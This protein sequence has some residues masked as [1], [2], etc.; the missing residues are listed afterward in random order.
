MANRGL[1]GDVF[2]D[3][4]PVKKHLLGAGTVATTDL[5]VSNFEKLVKETGYQFNIINDIL[6][7][8]I[9]EA[10]QS[11]TIK[12]STSFTRTLLCLFYD[13]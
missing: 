11:L 5:Y 2:Q 8:K 3:R 1:C 6:A 4:Q 13:C 9:M 7:V 12:V 10:R